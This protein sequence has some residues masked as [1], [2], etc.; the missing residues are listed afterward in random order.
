VTAPGP[1][2]TCKP[3]VEMRSTH[4]VTLRAL[5]D[6]AEGWAEVLPQHPFVVTSLTDGI[7][8]SDSRHYLGLA[9]DVRVHGAPQAHLELILRQFR[10][11]HP[12][13][14]AVVEAWGRPHEH[15]HVEWR[16][17]N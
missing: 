6:L 12:G 10:A 3:G 7:H 5:A 17:P 9:F 2:I 4:P 13:W 8:V 11:A 1:R 14:R 16:P 15:L